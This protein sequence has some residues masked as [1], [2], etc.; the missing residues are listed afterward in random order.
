MKLLH[1]VDTN[2]ISIA[3][4]VCH[5]GSYTVGL[6]YTYYTGLLYLIPLTILLLPSLQYP[7]AST[8]GQ[9]PGFPQ[10]TL[11]R[12]VPGHPPCL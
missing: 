12:R 11:I 7:R 1:N 6:L 9:T 5:I 10:N 4:D 3:L 2:L 8:A